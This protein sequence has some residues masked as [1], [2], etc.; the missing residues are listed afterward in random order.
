M[1]LL[2]S[3]FIQV[4]YVTWGVLQE[5]IMTK[6]Y[7]G[8]GTADEGPAERFTN[9]QFLVLVNRILA[10]VVASIAV[11]VIPHPAHATPL[12]KYSF[13]SISNILSSWCQYEA[14]KFVTFPTQVRGYE[15][16]LSYSCM[17]KGIGMLPLRLSR[18]DWHSMGRSFA[19]VQQF[20]VRV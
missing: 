9:S 15:L 2:H 3:V 5:R 1:N 19:S 17:S 6:K 10:F 7:G 16:F 8:S 20:T 13:C 12:Y 11:V 4:S 14:L 18:H